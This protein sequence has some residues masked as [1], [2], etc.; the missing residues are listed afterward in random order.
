MANLSYYEL[1]G[2]SLYSAK[3][4][5]Y[6][7]KQLSLKDFPN[8]LRSNRMLFITIQM[9]LNA[10]WILRN[11]SF[12]MGPVVMDLKKNSL[13][14]QSINHKRMAD[15]FS[16]RYRC[17]QII[18]I[19]E[20]NIRV[21]LKLLVGIFLTFLKEIK[22]IFLFNN[23]VVIGDYLRFL[24][25]KSIFENYEF[26]CNG[27]VI[28]LN[29]H[30]PLEVALN[31]VLRKRQFKTAYLQHSWV[32]EKWPD[33]NFDYLLLDGPHFFSKLCRNN[34]DLDV[35]YTGNMYLGDFQPFGLRKNQKI[36]VAISQ[37][38]RI[39]S[40]VQLVNDL[41]RILPA[42]EVVLRWHPTDSRYTHVDLAN[43]NHSNGAIESSKDHLSR[44]DIL[45][46]GNTNMLYEA[47]ASGLAV[48]YVKSFDDSGYD[49]YGFVGQGVIT[50]YDL[51]NTEN[52]LSDLL[53]FYSNS[54]YMR[55][56]NEFCTGLS[57]DDYVN[58]GLQSFL[59]G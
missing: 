36:S 33:A 5:A 19:T 31:Q 12:R 52:I 59:C 48:V 8:G 20:W 51:K 1:L 39:S 43:Y 38:T 23:H 27:V 28:F 42:Y 30:S 11:I 40:I 26:K 22:N 58:P 32:N 53:N 6:S 16:S 45:L 17:V 3:Q 41:N 57:L 54:Y 56:E 24:I 15:I 35:F 13:L 7:N 25:V 18:D 46:G 4:N 37:S 21:P 50:E 49:Y 29:D 9:L 44:V 55:L 47:A 2:T 10:F 14:T 34:R